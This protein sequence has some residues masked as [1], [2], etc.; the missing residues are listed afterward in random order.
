VWPAEAVQDEDREAEQ[1]S[2]AEEVDEEEEEEGHHSEVA[3]DSPRP[4]SSPRPLIIRTEAPSEEVSPSSLINRNDLETDQSSAH[5][6]LRVQGRSAS[7]STATTQPPSESNSGSVS[8]QQATSP[9]AGSFRSRRLGGS[10]QAQRSPD[11]SSK[12]ESLCDQTIASDVDTTISLTSTQRIVPLRLAIK[13]SPPS[14]AMSYHLLEGAEGK[15]VDQRVHSMPLAGLKPRRVKGGQWAWAEQSVESLIQRLY[16]RHP[17][18]LGSQK[19]PRIAPAQLQKLV[20]KL[21]QQHTMQ[22]QRPGL[23][24]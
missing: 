12:D 3:E 18:Y 4:S 6:F 13:F 15:I 9:S 7:N 8:P 16:K 14:L 10:P 23:A 21:M 19:D 11:P 5:H 1:Q 22:M 17:L 24:K 20:Q 2:D